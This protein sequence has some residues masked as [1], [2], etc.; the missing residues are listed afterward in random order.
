MVIFKIEI[1]PVNADASAKGLLA[2]MYLKCIKRCSNSVGKGKNVLLAAVIV[3]GILGDS[4][5]ARAQSTPNISVDLSVFNDAGRPGRLGIT[6][7]RTL[8]PSRAPL[9]TLH[10][11]PKKKIKLRAPAAARKTTSA[12]SVQKS[13]PKPAP[14]KAASKLVSQP[15]QAKVAKAPMSKAPATKAM[16]TPPPVAKLTTPAPPPA[17]KIASA[18]PAAPKVEKSP[19]TTTATPKSAAPEVASAPAKIE[20]KPGR[21]LRIAFGDTEARLP[22]GH[23]ANLVAL[24]NALREKKGFRL[25]LQAYAGGQDLSTSKA[26]RM[27]LS[28]AL[29]VRSFLIGKG[30][31]STQIDVRA[32]GNKTNEKPVNRVDLN[33]TKR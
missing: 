14:K 16:Q 11:A 6:G 21:A 20:M 17:P 7:N 1:R 24:A 12:K 26:R 19:P 5:T 33:L 8:P 3:G 4:A 22:D 10:I 9:S 29:A 15:T 2:T 28:R 13:E 30:V 23:Q 27:S 32:L 25:Q 18:P 31:R